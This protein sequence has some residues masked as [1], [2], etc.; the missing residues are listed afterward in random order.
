MA[1]SYSNTKNRNKVL[2]SIGVTGCFTTPSIL[3]LRL[4]VDIL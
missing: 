2:K 3:Y 4:E 1:G